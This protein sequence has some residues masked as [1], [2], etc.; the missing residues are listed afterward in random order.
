MK[1]AATGK[2]APGSVSKVRRAWKPSPQP[3]G[4]FSRPSVCCNS[5]VHAPDRNGFTRSQSM[6]LALVVVLLFGFLAW[7]IAENNG[8]YTHMISSE[9]G[10]LGRQ[11]GL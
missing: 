2:V 11:L 3:G 1:V 5:G 9:I 8:H 10:D 4:G 6:R 7:D